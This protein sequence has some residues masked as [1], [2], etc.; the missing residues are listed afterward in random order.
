MPTR[1]LAVIFGT[2]IVFLMTGYS[3]AFR[4]NIVA[5]WPFDEGSGKDICDISGK[6]ILN[7]KR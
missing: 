5:A 3:Y 4:D 7:G 6:G 1:L 2:A